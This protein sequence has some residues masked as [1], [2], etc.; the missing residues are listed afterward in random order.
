MLT[1]SRLE[2]AI[3]FDQ[4]AAWLAEVTGPVLAVV[5]SAEFVDLVL[6]RATWPVTLSCDAPPELAHASARLAQGLLPEAIAQDCLAI[7]PVETLQGERRFSGALWASPRRG[8]AATKLAALGRLLVPQ[9]PLC[10]L[11]ETWLASA[12][13]RSLGGKEWQP[14]PGVRGVGNPGAAGWAV[15]GRLAM[16]A[17]RPD[18]ADRAE[19]A[20]H[21]T[22]QQ[23]WAAPYRLLRVRRS[24]DR[25]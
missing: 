23:P 10:L 17:Q 22:L 18:L 25:A 6:A 3:A 12:L 11:V 16:L 21:L 2:H 5:S 4:A 14:D 24:G 8:S 13:H 9:S 7:G 20:H 19:R 15:T 1:A